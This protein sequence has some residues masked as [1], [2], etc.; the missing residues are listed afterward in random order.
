MTA[1]APTTSA[2]YEAMRE[3][4]ERMRSVS[5]DLRAAAATGGTACAVASGT[6]PGFKLG[7]E[8]MAACGVL[9]GVIA[10]LAALVD[11]QAGELDETCRIFD[12]AEGRN[13]RELA[14]P[15]P[16]QVRLRG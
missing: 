16:D 1:P 15:A 9:A 3:A 12:G 8:A 13:V 4:A 5:G 6:L 11:D 14:R 7:M 2:E 10:Q